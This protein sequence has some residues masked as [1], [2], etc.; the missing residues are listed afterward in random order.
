[1]SMSFMLNGMLIVVRFRSKVAVLVGGGEGR[2][3]VSLNR[4]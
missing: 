4:A 1:M 2:A 3:F